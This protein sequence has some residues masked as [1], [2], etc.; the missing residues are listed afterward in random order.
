MITGVKKVT[1]VT[2]TSSVDKKRNVGGELNADPTAVGVPLNV[3]TG[4][5]TG[6]SKGGSVEWECEGPIVFSYQLV[7]LRRKKGTWAKEEYTKGAF[8][9]IGVEEEEEVVEVD[10][11]DEGDIAEGLDED[12]VEVRDD[13]WD[14]LAGEE[15][16]VIA[17][18]RSES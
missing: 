8:M 13:G 11:G 16:R 3:G 18:L 4:A 7:K 9:S 17:P 10:E 2:A 14:D 6:C 5:K 12:E 1:G 15:C